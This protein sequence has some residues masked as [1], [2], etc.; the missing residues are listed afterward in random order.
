MPLLTIGF[1]ILLL[2]TIR[3]FSQARVELLMAETRVR[4]LN[5]A[6]QLEAD[7]FA[8]MNNT[9][10]PD[11]RAFAL[12]SKIRR[13]SSKTFLDIMHLPNAALVS[14]HF[15]PASQPGLQDP[16][17]PQWLQAYEERLTLELGRF[18]LARHPIALAVLLS[19]MPFK[20]D[21]AINNQDPTE[22]AARLIGRLQVQ[23]AA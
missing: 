5:L 13:Y 9:G 3:H 7:A 4:L 18:M 23:G 6:E 1:L 14:I 2:V 12:L 15:K 22:K 21:M 11:P 8:A 19:L 16:S 17:M 10:Q 20:P